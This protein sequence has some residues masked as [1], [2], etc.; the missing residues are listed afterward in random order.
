MRRDPQKNAR[1]LFQVASDQ[2]GY[3]SATQAL[4]VGYAYSQQHFHIARGNW[5]RV[6]HG[7][8]RLRDYPPGG[9][10]DLI[11]LSLWSHNR[12][13]E[14]QAVVSHHTALAV[15]ELSDL[16]PAQIHLTVPS[17]F[18]KGTPRGCVLHKATLPE[19]DV[20]QRIGYSVTTPLRTLLDVAATPLSQEHLN[21]AVEDALERGLVRRR[22][23]ETAPSSPMARQRLGRALAALKHQESGNRW[24]VTAS[25]RLFEQPPRID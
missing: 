15:H 5:I 24:I 9:R 17:R 3:F 4:Q 2:G 25:L 14:R 21:K 13:G 22:L 12:Q 7:I 16:M 8:F 23:L 1:K 18:R 20:E 10:E 6:D 19:D 11:H